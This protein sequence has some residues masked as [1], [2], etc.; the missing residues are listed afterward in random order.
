MAKINLLERVKKIEKEVA[1][2]KKSLYDQEKEALK[3][4]RAYEKVKK[5]GK[6]K[7]LESFDE[8]WN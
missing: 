8:L 3:A 6:L 2:V 4:V 7:K 1:E 5:E